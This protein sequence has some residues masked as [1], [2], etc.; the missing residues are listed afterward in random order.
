MLFKINFIKLLCFLLTFLAYCNAQPQP[1]LILKGSITGIPDG[2]LVFLHDVMRKKED[3]TRMKNGR[4]RF[5]YT[6]TEGSQYSLMIG[7][8]GVEDHTISLYLHPNSVIAVEGSWADRKNLRLTGNKYISDWQE[9]QN[10]LTE[11]SLSK[12]YT[13]SYGELFGYYFM[14]TQ[15]LDTQGLE[16]TMPRTQMEMKKQRLIGICRDFVGQWLLTHPQSLINGVVISRFF[17]QLYLSKIDTTTHLMEE[18]LAKIQPEAKNNVMTRMM[19]NSI[20]VVKKIAPGR[21]APDFAELDLQGKPVRL[22]DFRGRYVLLEFWASWCAP[23]RAENPILRSAYEKYRHKNLSIVS[24]SLDEDRKK[25]TTAVQEDDLPWMQLSALKGFEGTAAI[26][27][28]VH[29]IPEKFLIDPQGILIARGLR[30]AALDKKLQEV[31]R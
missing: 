24:I 8:N 3:S 27:F 6:T 12:E 9:Y 29:S 17:Y 4:F 19:I 10:K 7:R 25:W 5:A 1:N 22:S 15:Q 11:D 31:F 2:T 20:E 26:L 21:P 28:D 18:Y 16:K 23:C 30:G 13:N 14:I